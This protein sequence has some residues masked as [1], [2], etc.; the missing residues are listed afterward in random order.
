[1]TL[2]PVAQR[3]VDASLPPLALSSER[4]D[5]IGV[6]ADRRGHFPRRRRRPASADGRCSKL[7]GP[8]GRRQIWRIV[9]VDPGGGRR[10]FVPNSCAFLI[11]MIRRPPSLGVHTTTTIRSFR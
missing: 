11:E 2:E 4:R 5:D 7:G 10:A 6:K 1:M 3:G 9:R 8:F